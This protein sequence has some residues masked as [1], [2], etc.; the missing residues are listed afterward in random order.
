[1]QV[2]RS[3]GEYIE[4]DEQE[5]RTALFACVLQV[6]VFQ[7]L[8]LAVYDVFA[9]RGTHFSTENARTDSLLY[10]AFNEPYCSS[11]LYRNRVV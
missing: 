10:E 2:L 4:R 8:F 11:F 1:M 3:L 7:A 6:S 5:Q 9:R